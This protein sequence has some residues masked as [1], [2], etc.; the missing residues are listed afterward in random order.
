MCEACGLSALHFL[1]HDAARSVAFWRSSG[2]S[3]ANALRADSL[4]RLSAQW[5]QK[6]WKAASFSPRSFA[7]AMRSNISGIIVFR[8]IADH[9]LQAEL[10]QNGFAWRLLAVQ[11]LR[12]PCP[13]DPKIV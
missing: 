7:S 1:H 8:H 9:T 6:A 11:H 3:F 10:S 13:T 4:L 2:L 5:V 12:H